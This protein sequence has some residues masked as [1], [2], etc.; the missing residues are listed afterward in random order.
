MRNILL[1]LAA[2]AALFVG[3]LALPDTADARPVR[4]RGWNYG[5]RYQPYYY[6]YRYSYRPYVYRY[7]RYYN[8]YPSYYAYPRYYGAPG[9][10]VGARPG[11]Y[12]YW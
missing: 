9:V 12:F 4:Y 1:T 5:Y 3:G 10:Y 2:T 11:F 8:T 6:G 7:P